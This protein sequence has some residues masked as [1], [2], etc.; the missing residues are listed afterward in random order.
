MMPQSRPALSRSHVEPSRHIPPQP[1][2]A[3]AVRGSFAACDGE[4]VRAAL[5]CLPFPLRVVE[6]I[7][8]ELVDLGP[9]HVTAAHA[10]QADED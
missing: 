10:A 8:V 7:N 2:A 3:A 5:A 9:T 6:Q 1:T 4:P